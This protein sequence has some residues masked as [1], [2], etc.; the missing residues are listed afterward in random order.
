MA[1]SNSAYYDAKEKSSAS[2]SSHASA[3]QT[4]QPRIAYV[5]ATH[6]KANGV[7]SPTNLS[8]KLTWTAAGYDLLQWTI[9]D[10]CGLHGKPV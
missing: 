1:F 7:L 5:F 10:F 2:D 3:K 4:K 8:T 6:E 9:D